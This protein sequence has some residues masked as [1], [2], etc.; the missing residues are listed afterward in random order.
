MNWYIQR[1]RTKTNV[2]I[3]TPLRR[4]TTHGTWINSILTKTSSVFL[5][6]FLYIPN[7]DV[8]LKTFYGLLQNFEHWRNGIFVVV[9]VSYS[10]FRPILINN[11]RT[12]DDDEDGRRWINSHLNSERYELKKFNWI[13]REDRASE[14]RNVNDVKYSFFF[15]RRVY[16]ESSKWKEKSEV[17]KLNCYQGLDY[18]TFYVTK[19]SKESK[20]VRSNLKQ[21][22]FFHWVES[23]M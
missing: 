10:L 11:S 8:V 16:S 5:P 4:I 13:T 1:T 12:H 20:K 6:H 3:L 7:V 2:N 21:W 23:K 18:E 15:L 17:P 14:R 22:W 9:F 19:L